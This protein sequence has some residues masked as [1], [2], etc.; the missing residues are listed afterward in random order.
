MAEDFRLEDIDLTQAALDI[1]TDKDDV[2]EFTKVKPTDTI[3]LT[4]FKNDKDREKVEAWRQS[5]PFELI[6]K[7]QISNREL[8]DYAVQTFPG[9]IPNLDEFR[10][11]GVSDG[12]LLSQLLGYRPETGAEAVSKGIQIGAVEGGPSLAGGLAAGST[13]FQLSGGNP[14]ITLAIGTL[15]SIVTLPSGAELKNMLFG[16]NPW[17]PDAVAFGETGRTIGAGLLFS[18]APHV[19]ANRFSP[20]ALTLSNNIDI[21]TRSRNPFADILETYA[22]RPGMASKIETSAV[23]GSATGTYIAENS[24]KD[25]PLARPFFETTLGILSPV[26]GAVKVGEV[27]VNKVK[28]LFTK[29]A[30]KDGR[31]KLQGQAFTDFI[32]KN[33]GN[34]EQILRDLQSYEEGT[35]GIQKLAAE[36]GVDLKPVE[37]EAP[38]LALTSITQ[39]PAIKK[40]YQTMLT[41]RRSGVTRKYG[42]T[43]ERAIDLDYATMGALIDVMSRTGNPALLKKAAEMK[44]LYMNGVITRLLGQKNDR[45]KNA[46]SQMAKRGDRNLSFTSSKIIEDLTAQTIKDARDIEKDFY[47]QVDGKEVVTLENFLKEFELKKQE[48][49]EKEEQFVPAAV[50]NFIYR[51]SGTTLD[52]VEAFDSRIVNLNNK[53]SRSTDKIEDIGAVDLEAVEFV[54]NFIKVGGFPEKGTIDTGVKTYQGIPTSNADMVGFRE[55]I[56]TQYAESSAGRSYAKA[57]NDFREVIEDAESVASADDAFNDVFMDAFDE[58]ANVLDDP[59]MSP[60]VDSDGIKIRPTSFKDLDFFKQRTLAELKEDIAKFDKLDVKL[61]AYFNVRKDEARSGA[62]ASQQA[63]DMVA[64]LNDQ[65]RA[66]KRVFSKQKKVLLEYEKLAKKNK[67]GAFIETTAQAPAIKPYRDYSEEDFAKLS[68][69]EKIEAQLEEIQKLLRDFEIEDKELNINDQFNF[70]RPKVNRIKA[71]L[72]EKAKILNNELRIADIQN[73]FATPSTQEFPDEVTLQE[74]MRARTLLLEAVRRYSAA[75]NNQNLNYARILGDLADSIRKDFGVKVG[76]DDPSPEELA[77]L[78]PN[79]KALRDAYLFSKSLADTFRRAFP[80]DILAKD[81]EGARVLQPELLHRN[82]FSGGGDTTSLKI[83]DLENAMMFLAKDVEESFANFATSKA[84]TMR[85][86]V[87]DLLQVASRKIVDADGRVSVKALNDFKAEMQPVL[88]DKD[89]NEKFPEFMKL[90]KNVEEAQKAFNTMLLKTGDPRVKDTG[91]S[92]LFEG[93]GKRAPSQGVYQQKLKDQITYANFLNTNASKFLKTIIGSPGQR[94]TGDVE[95]FKRAI[96]EA[97]RADAKY[98]GAAKGLKDTVFDIAK[99]YS[100]GKMDKAGNSFTNFSAMK[101]FLTSPLEPNGP[102]LIEVMRTSNLMD[103]TEAIRLNTLLNNAEKIQKSFMGS[104]NLELKLAQGEALPIE[105]MGRLFRTVVNLIGLSAG[106]EIGSFIPGRGSGLAEPVLVSREVLDRVVTVPEEL[107]GDVFLEAASN[108]SLFKLMLQQ[109]KTRQE[110]LKIAQSFN[111]FLFTSGF[112]SAADYEGFKQKREEEKKNVVVPAEDPSVIGR[113]TKPVTPTL[114]RPDVIQT[115]QAPA[116]APTTNIAAVSPSL[117]N[118]APPVQNTAS[119]NAP[120]RK[121]FA[122]LFPE[123]RALI[124]GIGSLRG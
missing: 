80:G 33:G 67:G 56:H 117:N 38:T 19:F 49:L 34:R 114:V 24:Y 83:D 47:K 44:E 64:N 90:I 116:A 85:A 96:R 95:K 55:S 39:D 37:G 40:L 30:S 119:A 62:P 113:E 97:L 120:L 13:A 43:I 94:Q 122:A 74:A 54:N 115:S 78:T 86:A 48:I 23:L 108:P 102:S 124:E 61:E 16:D 109:G 89:N 11:M 57:E 14:L 92:P 121:R 59:S 106:G 68:S 79:Q 8:L 52:E 26:L 118:I 1:D 110:R 45:A 100:T 42:P 101:Q 5:F 25:Q 27:A 66:A 107:L 88:Y 123:D 22:R 6:E 29:Y 112:I 28:N 32:A 10:D 111:T 35:L 51:L 93:T 60:T 58:A 105:G 73:E 17:T 46:V 98:P 31:D 2:P 4:Q 99:V 84:G 82:I 18:K 69:S 50:R 12:T 7:S 104:G 15:G 41:E 20:G 76:G 77:A 36:L 87:Q 3:F 21:L 75:G 103:T 70:S 91:A 53:I 72:N 9:K 65:L 63:R 71:V 81:L